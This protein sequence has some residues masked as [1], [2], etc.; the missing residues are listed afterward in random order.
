MA[1]A[2]WVDGPEVLGVPELWNAAVA[3]GSRRRRW[4]R[5]WRCG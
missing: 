3:V 5:R 1:V 4:R 2:V